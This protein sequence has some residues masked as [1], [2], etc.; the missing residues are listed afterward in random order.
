[1]KL[2]DICKGKTEGVEEE[3]ITELDAVD[4]PGMCLHNEV[5]TVP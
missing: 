3:A 1:M 5:L 2:I 4:I